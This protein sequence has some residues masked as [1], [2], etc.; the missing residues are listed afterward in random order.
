M[1]QYDNLTV[2]WDGSPIA[3]DHINAA[4]VSIRAGA[5]SQSY[6]MQVDRI[7]GGIELCKL[8]CWLSSSNLI[9]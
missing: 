5:K 9:S 8:Q 4:H 7:A 2:G 6:V 3:G 1:Y